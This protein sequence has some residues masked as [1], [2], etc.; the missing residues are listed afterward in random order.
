MKKL[1]NPFRYLPLRQA[2]C[3]GIVALILMSVFCWQVG[4]RMSSI[5]QINY[6]GG[7]LMSATL[8]QLIAWLLFAVVLYAVGAVVSKSKVRFWDVAAFNLF[9]RI[10]F[11]LSLLMFA[12]PSVRSIMGLITD[13]SFETAMQYMNLLMVVGLV[14]MLFSIWYFFWSYKAFAE[15]TNIKNGKGVAI[16][17]LTFVVV[18]LVSP[19]VLMLV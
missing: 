3:W 2:L 12:I 6:A 19:Y 14:S 18:Y 1:I 5:T 9:A 16:F 11:D 8:Q 15:A 13:G 10:P 17:V 7:S 4:L